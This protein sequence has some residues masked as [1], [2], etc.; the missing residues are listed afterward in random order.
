MRTP[1]KRAPK[2]SIDP[3]STLLLR[4]PKELR[5]RL[6]AAAKREGLSAAEWVRQAIDALLST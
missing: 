5:E 6:D 3:G 4:M 2:G 1:P